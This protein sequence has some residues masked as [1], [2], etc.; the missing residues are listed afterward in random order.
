[1]VMVSS[2]KDYHSFHH[3]HALHTDYG[4]AIQQHQRFIRLPTKSIIVDGKNGKQSAD[5]EADPREVSGFDLLVVVLDGCGVAVTPPV[6]I[7]SEFPL[8]SVD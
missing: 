7:L 8:R 4:D 5:A 1:M 2:L 3:R 6:S